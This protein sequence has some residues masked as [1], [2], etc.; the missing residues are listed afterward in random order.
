MNT[1]VKLGR[2]VASQQ[3][4][5][6][7]EQALKPGYVA[8][9]T[10]EKFNYHQTVKDCRYFYMRD[11]IAGTVINRICEIGITELKN[12][13]KNKN[14]RT[15]VPDAVMAYYNAVVEK[16]KPFLTQM[17]LEYTLTGMA[18]PEYTTVR[19]MGNRETD[20]L[21]RTRYYFPDK[22]WIRNVDNIEVIK[23]PTGADRVI[24]LK[25]PPDEVTLIKEKGGKNPE[26][27][28]LYNLLLTQFPDYVKAVESG[29]TKFLLENKN[30]ILRKLLSNNDYPL[31][32]LINALDPMRHKARLKAMD[33][34]IAS[35]IL[36]AVRH[37][38]VGNDEFPADDDTIKSE[39]LAFVAYGNSGE[40]I[41]NYFSNHTIDIS[42]SYPPFEA[43]LDEKKYGEPN[44]E[45][46]FALGFPRIW[47]NGE[48]EKSNAADNNLASIG[49]LAMINDL[50]ST[51]L[52][53][54]K[55]FYSELA[56]L[57]GFD[58]IP[59]VKFTDISMSDVTAL[60]QYA[61]TMFEAGA[62]SR[63]TLAGFYGKD[64]EG[65]Y[66]QRLVEKEKE[67]ELQPDTEVIMDND[68]IN[69]NTE[70]NEE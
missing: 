48:T 20:Y 38:K 49:P 41:F 39:Q 43:L 24:F 15:P 61:V 60:I 3:Q 28:A 12:V 54:V 2:S 11:P 22:L 8:P 19:K 58:R 17:A 68:V 23:L 52:Q 25:V 47:V 34:S 30:P 66:E 56:E 57:N 10:T 4:I 1:S 67:D 65:E 18:I 44:R 9:E 26:R 31:P 62:I 40:R 6:F 59:D 46:F 27:Q 13:R 45:I 64:Y 32:Y 50:R 14:Q 51:I 53:W 36:E 63:E 42:W 33:M 37:I 70:V 7:P 29:Q 35:R 69:P 5:A 21:G 55:W 16:L